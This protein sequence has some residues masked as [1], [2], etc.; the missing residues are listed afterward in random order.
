[1]IGKPRGLSTRI[2]I[3]PD[4][5]TQLSAPAVQTRS[6]GMGLAKRTHSMQ[7]RPG[8]A[9][10]RLTRAHQSRVGAHLL[11][12]CS[13][14]PK[15]RTQLRELSGNSQYCRGVLIEVAHWGH[16]DRACP[17]WARGIT[18]WARTCQLWSDE[19]AWCRLRLVCPKLGLAKDGRF[20]GR[21][22]LF[23]GCL[24][25]GRVFRPRVSKSCPRGV[26][27]H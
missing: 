3:I 24:G 6:K 23:L 19:E 2:V 27:F 11:H 18:I 15:Y 4:G 26:H 12:V 1:M 22:G 17:S 8:L 16:G 7:N 20:R 14:P 21:R 5:P 10:G 25:L 13:R 9:R